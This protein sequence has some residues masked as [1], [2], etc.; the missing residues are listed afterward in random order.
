M[1]AALLNKTQKG[2]NGLLSFSDWGS[3]YKVRTFDV[4]L[5]C[6]KL[7]CLGGPNGP[8]ICVRRTKTDF[9]ERACNIPEC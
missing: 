7:R 1:L 4:F 9:K 2:N 3:K 6:R 5:T 8:K